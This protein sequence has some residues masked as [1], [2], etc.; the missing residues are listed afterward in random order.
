MRV[1]H[2]RRTKE[3]IWK[4][5]HSDFGSTTYLFQSILED[6]YLRR[7]LIREGLNSTEFFLRKLVKI[8]FE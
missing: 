4:T 5:F 7:E 1:R 3:G 8:D 2:S 6:V